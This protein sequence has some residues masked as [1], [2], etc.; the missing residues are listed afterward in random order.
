MIVRS[1]AVL[2]SSLRSHLDGSLVHD[3]HVHCVYG[4]NTKT[5]AQDPNLG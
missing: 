2:I 5:H 4:V 3:V 1:D